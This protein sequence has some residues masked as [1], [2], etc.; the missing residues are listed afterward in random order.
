MN[1]RVRGTHSGST[2]SGTHSGRMTDDA[3]GQ[4]RAALKRT[5]GVFPPPDFVEGDAAEMLALL[6]EITRASLSCD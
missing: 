3:C 6:I 2:H 5:D 1:E 4:L